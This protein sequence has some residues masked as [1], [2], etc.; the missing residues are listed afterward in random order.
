MCLR[1]QPES[2]LE[3]L[4]NTNTFGGQVVIMQS[5]FHLGCFSHVDKCPSCGSPVKFET[6]KTSKRV[7]DEE[8]VYT[9]CRLRCCKKMCRIHISLVEHTIWEEIGDW[10]L[11]V[12]VVGAF[13]NRW[14]TTTVAQMTGSREDTVS[15]YLKVIKNA[16][17]LEVEATKDDFVLGGEGRRVQMDESHVFTRK[18]E[19]GVFLK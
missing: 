1:E 18:Y 12:F 19:S 4:F 13:L 17:H 11:F 9:T 15:K 16:I 8:R 6:V 10:T 14:S 3:P 5:L 7:G 2:H